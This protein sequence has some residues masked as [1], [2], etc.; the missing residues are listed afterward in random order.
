MNYRLDPQ[1]V[2]S[3][4]Q[5]IGILHGLRHDCIARIIHVER[6]PRIMHLFYDIDV[7][8]IKLQDAIVK[9]PHYKD[10]FY[11]ARTFRCIMSAIIFCDV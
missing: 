7:G 10:I 11:I 1:F 4:H 9:V 2:E 3:L 6:Y 8:M 5:E